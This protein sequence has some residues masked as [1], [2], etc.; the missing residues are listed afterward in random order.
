MTIKKHNPGSYYIEAILTNKKDSRYSLYFVQEKKRKCIVKNFLLPH[1]K[2]SEVDQLMA[3]LMGTPIAY[4]L[5]FN[6]MKGRRETI[7]KF[8]KL[9]EKRYGKGLI[10]RHIEE[11]NKLNF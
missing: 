8:W 5:Q 10:T 2:K 4:D 11:I 9:Y 1:I 6:W 7:E 3:D